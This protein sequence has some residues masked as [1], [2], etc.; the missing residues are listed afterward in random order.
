M[1]RLNVCESCGLHLQMLAQSIPVVSKEMF[2][3]VRRDT[4]RLLHLQPSLPAMPMLRPFVNSPPG[5]TPQL[6]PMRKPGDWALAL[7]LPSKQSF[8]VLHSGALVYNF[9]TKVKPCFQ[10]SPSS[11]ECRIW[12]GTILGVERTDTD[13]FAADA[14][15]IAGSSLLGSSFA[16]RRR[17]LIALKT[18]MPELSLVDELPD[19]QG[20]RMWDPTARVC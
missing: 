17:H 19:P 5:P 9:H 14:Y 20:H 10:D 7:F 2:H 3:C 8:F 15:V 16:E 13:W 4:L 6:T 1:T 18:C 12:K 11:N